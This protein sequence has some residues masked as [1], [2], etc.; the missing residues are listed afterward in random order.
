MA[1]FIK[2]WFR[3][4]ETYKRLGFQHKD[5]YHK[6]PDLNYEFS[7]LWYDIWMGIYIDNKNRLIYV[8]PFPMF[9]WKIG[10]FE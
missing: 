5:W 9:V 3:G 10:Y 6:W 4:G 2:K 1:N 8:V 7:F